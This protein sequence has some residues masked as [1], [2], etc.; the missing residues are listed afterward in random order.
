M[1]TARSSNVYLESERVIVREWR[2]DEVEGMHRWYGDQTV[3]KFLS[4]GADSWE[5]SE[6]YL[7]ES[8]VPSQSHNPRIEFYLAVELR[9]S[10]RTIGDVGF[11]W[12]EPGVAEIGY[13]LE[14]S[15]WGHGYATEAA[16]RV[17]QYAF[18]LGAEAVI[19]TCDS[20]NTS[21]ERVMQRCGMQRQ[22]TREPGRQLYRVDRGQ[23][24]MK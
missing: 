8:V 24:E 14:P 11:E 10:G 19:A 20:N 4:F 3:R 7:R 23:F 18:E 6:K 2:L 22:P 12:I 13:F 5:E 21:S 16:A 1:S 15:Y 9:D 17:I